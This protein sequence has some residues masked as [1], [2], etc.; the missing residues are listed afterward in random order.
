VLVGPIEMERTRNVEFLRVVFNQWFFDEI[1]SFFSVI[2]SFSY[3]YQF[4]CAGWERMVLQILFLGPSDLLEPKQTFR[5]VSKKLIVSPIIKT[6]V[7][8]KVPEKVTTS[9][10]GSV[11]LK[12]CLWVGSH[13]RQYFWSE[14]LTN[15]L[16]NENLVVIFEIVGL[17][18]VVAGKGMGRQYHGRLEVQADYP[19]PF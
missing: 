8:N 6:L 15:N 16:A 9:R 19:L 4:R 14:V 10:I 11:F 17:S 12:L 3:N 7:Y 13:A 5:K 1:L 2:I 18:L